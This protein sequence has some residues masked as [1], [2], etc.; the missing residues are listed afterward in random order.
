[1]EYQ[2]AVSE[3]ELRTLIDLLCTQLKKEL[4]QYEI[5]LEQEYKSMAAEL[6]TVT[7]NA[8]YCL[9]GKLTLKLELGGE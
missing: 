7:I 4:E 6:Q 9:L 5:C 3:Y 2:I 1:M 8:L